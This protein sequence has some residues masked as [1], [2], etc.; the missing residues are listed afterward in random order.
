[1]SENIAEL[2]AQEATAA[3][4]A[5]AHSDPSEPLPAGTKVTRGHDRSRVVNVRVNA[6][7]YDR[8]ASYAEARSLP[9]STAVRALLLAS[10]DVEH[11]PTVDDAA[12]D[13]REALDRLSRDVDDVRR[14]ALSA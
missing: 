5:E 2:L 6:D 9:V 8:L 13:L 1:M 10:L 14:R 3:E 12:A 7:E 11:F 4:A